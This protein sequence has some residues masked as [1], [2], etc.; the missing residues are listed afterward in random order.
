MNIALEFISVKVP[1]VSILNP[2]WRCSDY[3]I[4]LS[5][6]AQGP[7]LVVTGIKGGQPAHYAARLIPVAEGVINGARSEKSPGPE[8]E[9]G[10][11]EG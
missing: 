8:A 5:E 11:K 2:A 6:C 1:D 7:I 3:F 10:P 9:P 4:S